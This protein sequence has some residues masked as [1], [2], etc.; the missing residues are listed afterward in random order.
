MKRDSEWNDTADTVTFECDL[1]APPD[2]VWRALTVPEILSAWLMPCDAGPGVGRFSLRGK[3][4]EGGTIVCEVLALEP[5]RLMRLT[6]R[7][8]SQPNAPERPLDTVVTF[9]LS[10]TRSGGTRLR[11]VHTGFAVAPS[12]WAS[13]RKAMPE[14][15]VTAVPF[16]PLRRR[17]PQNLR[18]PRRRVTTACSVATLSLRRAA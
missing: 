12:S 10:E 13:D 18:M 6:W 9:R 7:G 8:E 5:H 3:P 15:A 1:D 16:A 4:A 14:P 17:R 2:K 11:I